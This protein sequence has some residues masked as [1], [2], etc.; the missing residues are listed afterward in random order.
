MLYIRLEEKMENEII[1]SYNNQRCH[2]TITTALKGNERYIGKMEGYEVYQVV[3]NGLFDQFGF[4]AVKEKN[5]ME[6]TYNS[7]SEAISRIKSDTNEALETGDF[8]VLPSIEIKY[9][10]ICIN[11][12]L[13]LA[14]TNDYITAQLEELKQL[15]NDSYI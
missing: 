2:A 15:Y 7:L 5:P 11:I 12:P 4:V 1:F 10:D 9:K 13:N 3:N 14:E 6:K 8:D